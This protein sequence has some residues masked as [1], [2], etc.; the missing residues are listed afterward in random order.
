MTINDIENV[1]NEL[2]VDKN[3]DDYD[4]DFVEEVEDEDLL[5]EED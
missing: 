4:D 3:E 1:L 5:D 2:Q